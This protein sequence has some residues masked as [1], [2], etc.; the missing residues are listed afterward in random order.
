MGEKTILEGQL[1]FE[2]EV[3]PGLFK[4]GY[5]PR[6]DQVLVTME[7]TNQHSAIPRPEPATILAQRRRIPS[8]GDRPLG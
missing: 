3:R 5:P 1:R 6:G 2:T 4:F 7:Q 8:P